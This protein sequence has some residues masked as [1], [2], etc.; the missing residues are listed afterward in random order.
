MD[1]IVRSMFYAVGGLLALSA[2]VEEINLDELRPDPTLVVNCV[3]VT[4]EP[5]KVYVSR[6]WFV[7]ESRPDMP[8][9]EVEVDLYVNDRPKEGLTL[10][11]D[12]LFNTPDYFVSDYLPAAGDRICVEVSHP[13]LGEASAETEMPERAWFVDADVRLVDMDNSQSAIYEVTFRNDASRSDYYLLGL[14]EGIPVFDAVAKRYTGEYDWTSLSFDYATDPVIAGSFTALDYLFGADGLWASGGVVFSDELIDG[15]EYTLRLRQ[16][17]YH[18]TGYPIKVVPDSV[19]FSE[20]P[21]EDYTPIP[22][23]H[24]R[25]HLYTLSADYYNY[26]KAT[27]EESSSSV[28]GGLVDVGLAEAV[29]VYS[30]IEGGIGILGG[31]HVGTFEVE[32]EPPTSQSENDGY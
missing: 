26:L 22:P 25:V 27:Q 12:D 15:E 32:F 14:D 23:R 11:E 20:V 1:S 17:Y 13:E 5:L 4:G 8:L 2:C 18:D 21:E 28:M 19:R 16:D 6:T 7:T 9:D 31:C 3:A 30:N 29:R 10:H 24:L